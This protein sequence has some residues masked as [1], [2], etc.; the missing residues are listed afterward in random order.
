MRTHSSL[1]RGE[2][3]PLP[4]FDVQ[5]SVFDV[6]PFAP[7]LLVKPSQA[8]SSPVKPDQA[9]NFFRAITHRRFLL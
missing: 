2:V 6:A 7:L 9:H 1:F 8:Q 5:V 4:L 3:T